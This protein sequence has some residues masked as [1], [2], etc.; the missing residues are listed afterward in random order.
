[1]KLSDQSSIKDVIAAMSLAD[2]ARL[3]IGSNNYISAD[4]AVGATASVPE[5]GIP[6]LDMADGPA[7]V[8]ISPHRE[9][10]TNTFYATAYPIATMLASSWDLDLVTEV[11]RGC[12]NECLEYDIDVLLAPGLNIQRDPLN[13]RNFEYYSEDP[14]VA[15]KMA[16]AMVRGIQEHGVAATIKHFAANNQE[17]NRFTIDVAVSQR[18]LREIYLRAF[19]IAVKEGQP[20]AIMSSYNKLN[21][22][23]TPQNSDLLLTVLRDEW[24]FSNLVMTDWGGGDDPVATMFAGNDLIMPGKQEQME[25]IINA[26]ENGILTEDILDRNITNILT[27]I[28]KLPKQ[29]KYQPSHKP[30][31]QANAKLARNAASQGMVLLENRD[32]LP[33]AT[34]NKLAVF[35]NAQIE[36]IKGGTGSGDVNVERTVSLIT[37]LQ[38]LGYETDHN[39]TKVYQNYLTKNRKKPEYQSKSWFWGTP[40]IPDMP[41]DVTMIRESVTTSDAAIIIIGRNSGEAKDRL[42]RDDF[43]LTRTEQDLIDNVTSIFHRHG[44]MVIVLLNIPGPIE[45][46]S[47]RYKVDAILLVWQPGQEAGLAIADV[48]SGNVNPS[49]KLAVTFPSEYTDAPTANNFPGTPSEDPTRVIYEEDIYVGYRYYSTFDVLP[50]YHFGFGLSYTT[51]KYSDLILE[52]DDQDLSVLV[53]I[54]N[55]GPVAGREV[56]QLYVTKPNQDY[57]TPNLELCAFVKTKLLKPGEKQELTVN[58]APQTLAVFDEEDSAW[59]IPRGTHLLHISASSQDIRGT[60]K[61][62]HSLATTLETVNDVLGPQVEITRLS[63]N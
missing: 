12:G 50:A 60:L 34:D 35:G 49:G 29:K 13:G 36:T 30:N 52:Q 63:K 23:Y 58:I 51:F 57:E 7:G 40:V 20:W 47:W 6:A 26:V 21:G 28:L 11:G 61:Y 24:N 41:C 62:H 48:L 39:L 42:V 10:F 8:R 33:L 43:N 2:K 27:M 44:K 25:A 45:M 56:I 46:V 54:E 59:V 5:L 31:L 17:T 22:T 3:V 53:T 32:V 18:A 55:T 16:A 19:E 9:G 1:M 38:T 37:G 15:G 4:G 14:L